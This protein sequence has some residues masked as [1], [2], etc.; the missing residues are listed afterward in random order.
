MLRVKKHNRTCLQT[1]LRA[2]NQEA[3]ACDSLLEQHRAVSQL[4]DGRAHVRAYR[5]GEEFGLGSCRGGEERL[6]SG[7][8]PANNR[9]QV[10]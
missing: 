7:A 1:V 8:D 9:A 4:P 6:D 2:D 3:I 10:R 5:R